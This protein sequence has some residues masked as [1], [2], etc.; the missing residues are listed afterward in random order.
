MRSDWAWSPAVTYAVAYT[1]H[2]RGTTAVFSVAKV[3]S[4]QETTIAASCKTAE[5]YLVVI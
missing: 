2:E 5:P 3:R 1:G 4:E